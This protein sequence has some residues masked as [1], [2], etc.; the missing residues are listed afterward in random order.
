MCPGEFPKCRKEVGT[1]KELSLEIR[2]ETKSGIMG[3]VAV[4]ATMTV[5]VVVVVV[6]VV[7][8]AVTAL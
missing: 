4:M 1:G 2:V 6:M 8:K 5:V 3:V 7:E